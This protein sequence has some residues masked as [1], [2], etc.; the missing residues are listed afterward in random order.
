LPTV[1]FFLPSIATYRDR[2]QLLMEVS[3]GLQR[4]IL[5]VGNVDSHLDTSG[6]PG[7]EIVDAG[8]K[9][10]Q[11]PR[12]LWRLNRLVSRLITSES[13][14]IVHDT[15]ASL[16]PLMFRKSRYPGVVFLTSLFANE[17][18]RLKHVWGDVPLHRKLSSWSTATMYL[19]RVFERAVIKRSD[20][21][22]VQAPGLIERV[23]EFND[24]PASKVKILTNNVDVDEW[25][26][27]TIDTGA[28]RPDSGPLRLLFVGGVGRTRGVPTMVKAVELLGRRGVDATLTLVGSAEPNAEQELSHLAEGLGVQDKIIFAGRLNR[29]QVRDAFAMHD[30]FLYLTINDGSPRIVLEAVSTGIPTIATRHPGIEVMDPEGRAISY[31]G[32]EDAEVV[33]ELAADFVNNRP[34]W[35]EKAEIGRHIMVDRFA[36]Q[37]VARQYVALYEEL[38]AN[39]IR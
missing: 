13:V 8:F 19:N 33:A 15:Y 9:R 12:N 11:R 37:S 28:E 21:V 22:V 2:V 35:R 30:I 24:V 7:L 26:P 38:A 5:V 27:Q 36:S 20:Y 4:L 29:E 34:S 1:L 6:Y 14:D 25:S 23:T 39:P 17:G 16:V 18:W 32:H 31:A 3:R 10:R